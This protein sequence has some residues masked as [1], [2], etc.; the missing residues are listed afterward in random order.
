MFLCLLSWLFVSLL[1]GFSLC[2]FFALSASS[3]DLSIYFSCRSPSTSLALL[4]LFS[5]LSLL[6][7]FNSALLFF[8][9]C[10]FLHFAQSSSPNPFCFS[11][12]A[13]L[14]FNFVLVKSHLL[15]Q[16]YASAFLALLNWAIKKFSSLFFFSSHSKRNI[17]LLAIS[18]YINCFGLI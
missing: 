9:L 13:I 8:S 12:S 3:S 14:V 1:T 7:I 4:R 5:L 18:G 11:N 16:R 2:L 17:E 15:L 6:S 10:L